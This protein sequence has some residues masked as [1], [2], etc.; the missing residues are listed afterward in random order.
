MS[1]PNDVF[2]WGWQDSAT[3]VS[4]AL[5]LALALWLARRVRGRQA[6][7]CSGC[8]QGTATPRGATRV[9]IPTAG[10]RLGR[11]EGGASGQRQTGR[12]GGEQRLEA[13]RPEDD[14]TSEQRHR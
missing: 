9:V 5:L 14:R 10:L 4:C 13:E 7:G 8:A 1:A 2:P 12:P 6:G 3:L 11:R